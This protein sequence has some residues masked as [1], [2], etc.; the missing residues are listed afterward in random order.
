MLQLLIKKLL[1]ISLC[2]LVTVQNGQALV[3]ILLEVAQNRTPAM[4]LI[5]ALLLSLKCHTILQIQIMKIFTWTIITEIIILMFRLPINTL[6]QIFHYA[7]KEDWI[8]ALPNLDI[9][10]KSNSDDVNI[11]TISDPCVA[12]IS[13]RSKST[14]SSSNIHQIPHFDGA[15]KELFG[16]I[17]YD[18]HDY[19][20]D[21]PWFTKEDWVSV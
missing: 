20:Y 11:S 1:G 17:C 21:K 5:A 9:F 8:T 13:I 2:L 12:R 6:M 7:S 15:L 16:D 4:K 19:P 18:C 14:A 10:T 3:K